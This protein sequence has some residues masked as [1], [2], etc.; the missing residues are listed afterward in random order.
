MDKEAKGEVTQEMLK[1]RG[2]MARAK[3]KIDKELKDQQAIQIGE[4]I[5]DPDFA[6]SL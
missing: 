5:G 6:A 1:K 2:I 4:S 3:A